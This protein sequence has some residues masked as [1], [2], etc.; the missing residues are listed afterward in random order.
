[1]REIGHKANLEVQGEIGLGTAMPLLPPP[2]LETLPEALR[3]YNRWVVWK[4]F[5]DPGS[6]VTE[7]TRW[8][9]LPIS[10][11]TGEPVSLDDPAAF[12]PFADVTRA[13]TEDRTLGPGFVLG[14]EDPFS[15]IEIADALNADGKMTADAKSCL[16]RLDSYTERMAD[17][18]GMRVVIRGCLPPGGRQRADIEMYETERLIPLTTWHWA[19]TPERIETRQGN[20][21]KLHREIFPPAAPRRTTMPEP[22]AGDAELLV[23]AFRGMNGARIE[24]LYHGDTSGIPGDRNA[25]DLALCSMLGAYTGDDLARLNRLFRGSALYRLK[26]DERR[27]SDGSTYGEATVAKALE[28]YG[29]A[30]APPRYAVFLPDPKPEEKITE[31]ASITPAAEVA[32]GPAKAA[33]ASVSVATTP[34]TPATSA[35]VTANPTATLIPAPLFEN[36]DPLMYAACQGRAEGLAKREEVLTAQEAAELLKISPR[37]LRRTFTPWRRF[38]NSPRGDRW[39]LSQLLAAQGDE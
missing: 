31:T 19:G 26:W 13:C 22:P 27:Y 17:G 33:G 29:F 11:L 6:G 32:V 7:A 35:V 1:V 8:L 4:R 16:E 38:G 34:I 21:E 5:Y 23:R 15:V 18:R 12:S 24:R 14:E 37:L 9:V 25:A 30:P 28:G 2:V 3:R 10:A 36:V 20:V 39:L